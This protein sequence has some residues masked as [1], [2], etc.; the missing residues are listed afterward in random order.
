[1][2]MDG[3]R[4]STGSSVTFEEPNGTYSFVVGVPANFTSVPRSGSVTVSGAAQAVGIKFT[5]TG[6]V[7]E[8]AV[9]FSEMGLPPGVNWSVGIWP[10]NPF[11]IF[12]HN[13]SS[14][15]S[16]ISFEEPN[17]TYSFIV[18]P[19]AGYSASPS[20][21][22]GY[23]GTGVTVAGAPSSVSITFKPTPAKTYPVTIRESGLPDGSTWN[24]TL[25]GTL[26]STGNVSLTSSEPNG[27]YAYSIPEAAGYDPSPSSGVLSVSGAP[28]S[29]NVVF[30]PNGTQLAGQVY[31]VVFEQTGLPSNLTWGFSLQV[32][33]ATPA[34]A[35]PSCGQTAQG[36]S[37]T[38][39]L[40][41]G[42]FS[43][44]ISSPASPVY[45]VTP[46]S[47]T[48]TVSGGPSTVPLA[49][50]PVDTSSPTDYP[51]NFTE[52]GLP[53]GSSWSVA[54]KGSIFTGSGGFIAFTEPNGRYDPTVSTARAGYGSVVATTYLV[55]G[56]PVN[57][58]VHF[59]AQYAA[60]F[61]V[62]NGTN[63]PSYGVEI[64][65]LTNATFS[66]NLVTAGPPF[67]ILLPNGN[68]SYVVDSSE[69]F[70]FHPSR[71]TFTIAGHGVTIDFNYSSLKTDTVTFH[72]SGLPLALDWTIEEFPDGAANTDDQSS[73]GGPGASISYTLTNGSY[74]W[75]A[76]SQNASTNGRPGYLATPDSGGFTVDGTN[77]NVSV[78]FAP[79]P[80]SWNVTVYASNNPDGPP[81]AP[82]FGTPW[83]VT[84]NGTSY[85]T[86]GESLILGSPRGTIA[87]AIEAPPGYTA[88]PA[89][90][91]YTID[92]A[93]G[94][95]GPFN[96]FVILSVSFFN[97]S[98]PSA[99]SPPQSMHAATIHDPRPTVSREGMGHGSRTLGLESPLG[100]HGA[101]AAFVG[102]CFGSES[103]S[104][105]PKDAP[106]VYRPCQDATVKRWVPFF[107]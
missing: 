14:E 88:L 19:V 28:V 82:P 90:G 33:G 67:S 64:A 13:E 76:T 7:L 2:T 85:P 25:A 105:P 18:W 39:Y 98:H 78:S 61:A 8:Y 62:A 101:T 1:M 10:S 47:G 63:A 20:S 104:R 44:S 100:P 84:V 51:V 56:G 95:I 77:I 71:G 75:W 99:P 27:S 73:A 49:F 31:P 65:D 102:L 4:T 43:W 58:S 93:A 38:F 83:G 69:G 68:F 48:V 72:E 17:S 106:A 22:F 80:A 52:T 9:T 60:T 66:T 46:S 15:T 12:V 30:S 59:Y 97:A 21:G 89:R 81:V 41:N 50:T 36:G 3:I 24:L 79:R 55:D 70:A 16:S 37:G 96:L 91:F 11:P 94:G 6:V 34:A 32:V 29:T 92:P 42:T 103:F 35:E 45:A 87:Y 5:A 23:N 53:S 26:L 40:P 107:I 74:T 57:L 54:V 86:S